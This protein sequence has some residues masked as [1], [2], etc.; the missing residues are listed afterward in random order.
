[1]SEYKNDN[2]N[3]ITRRQIMQA[4]GAVAASAVTNTLI[5]ANAGAAE[6]NVK[7]EKDMTVGQ[8]VVARLKLLGVRQTFGVPGDFIYDICDAIEDDPDIQG[9]W[10]ANELNAGYAA[11]GYARTSNGIG[12]AVLTMGAE[13]SALQSMANANADSVPVLHLVGRPS[14]QE[15]ASGGR[16]HHMIS[17]MEGENFNLFSDITAPLTAGGEAVALITPENCVAEMERVIALMQY[18][19]K[20]GMLAFPRVVGQMPV[21]MPAGELNTPLANP[22]SDPGALNAAVREVLNRISNAKRPIWL[23]GYPIRRFDC[24][25]EAQAVIEASGL[26]FYTALQDQSVISETHPQYRGNYFGHWT[27]MADPAVSKFIEESDCIVGI[28]P[29]NHSF[30]NAFHTVKDELADTINIMP[31]ETRIGFSV[32]RNVNM[33]DLLVELASRIE[34][35]TT[36]VPAPM[37]SNKFSTTIEG[38]ASDEITYEPFYQRLQAFYRPNDV[39]YGCTSLCVVCGF[40]RAAKLEGMSL[41]TSPA[42]G[43]LGWGSAAVLG[44]A[45]AAADQGRRTVFLTG[46]GAHLMTANE[47]GAYGRYEL[48][49]IFIVVNNNGYGAERITNRYPDEKYNDVPQWDFADL[50]G[51]MG[52]K[53]WFTAKVS[54]LGEL[55]EALATAGNADVG[56]YIEVIIDQDEMPIGSD[57][58]FGA[59]GAYFGLAGR[60]WE[61]WLEQG[62]AMKL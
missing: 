9:I 18:H 49:P 29:E 11:E 25:A 35:R 3:R 40:G 1:M 22:V 52:C 37:Q 55:D 51:V 6:V 43:M 59:T 46:E 48:K 56:V 26:P 12:V 14:Q 13:L 61:Q 62:R 32:Y 57:W 17:G 53:D 20:P 31:R 30:N 19:S 8:Y 41:E 44:G 34:K 21:V 7:K 58:L 2:E 10:C 4:T 36:D 27:G 54:T 50:P 45:A 28:G 24:V 38:A 47:I 15:I 39:L 5:A 42:F 23:P 33:K 60:T 16:M